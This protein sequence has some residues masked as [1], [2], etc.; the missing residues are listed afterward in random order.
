[1]MPIIPDFWQLKAQREEMECWLRSGSVSRILRSGNQ[2]GCR[3]GARARSTKQKA[4]LER[5]EEM[6][7]QHGPQS[8]GQVSMSSITTRMGK[9]TI[10]IDRIS[11]NPMADSTFIWDF[12]YIFLK[13][14][15]DGI[16]QEPTDVESRH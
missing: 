7:N 12:S 9:T 14:D 3:R 8:D 13:N 10:E 4:R 11:A 16:C 1:M 2:S 15:R 6:K 5:Y